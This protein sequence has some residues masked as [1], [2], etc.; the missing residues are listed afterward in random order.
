MLALVADSGAL[1]VVGWWLLLWSGCGRVLS[2]LFGD[3]LFLG[4]CESSPAESPRT[5]L[6]GFFPRASSISVLV[7]VLWDGRVCSTSLSE[8][9]DDVDPLV[10][11]GFS[12]VGIG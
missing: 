6:R 9:V 5:R 8:A 1:L 3:V 12:Y 7:S 2:R 4:G 11:A 10:G